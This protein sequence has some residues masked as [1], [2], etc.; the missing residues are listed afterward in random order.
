MKP[1]DKK[2]FYIVKYRGGEYEDFY[3]K[4]IFITSDFEK[5]KKYVKKFNSILKKWKEYYSK[6]ED[7]SLGW[8]DSSAPYH[9]FEAWY[10]LRM[11]DECYYEEIEIR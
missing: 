6:Y 1:L 9:I 2:Y 5:V 8:A 11:I 10:R 4:D 3:T 7:K